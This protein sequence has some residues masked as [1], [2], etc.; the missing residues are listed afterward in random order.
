VPVSRRWKGQ[1]RHRTKPI[2]R[3]VTRWLLP[4]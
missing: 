1:Q 2:F 3:H 4:G